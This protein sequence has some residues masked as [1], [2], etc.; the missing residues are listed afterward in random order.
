MWFASACSLAKTNLNHKPKLTSE[1][2]QAPVRCSRTSA[3]QKRQ[4]FFFLG[5]LYCHGNTLGGLQFQL[6]PLPH[7]SDYQEE[8]NGCLQWKVC[9]KALPRVTTRP[10][11]PERRSTTT[12]GICT[13]WMGLFPSFSAWIRFNTWRQTPMTSTICCHADSFSLPT[14]NL[15]SSPN[16]ESH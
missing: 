4:R 15:I 12:R 8:K 10:C 7:V 3:R 5:I 9:V 11:P 16:N 2:K 13:S 6:H 1:Q 14:T